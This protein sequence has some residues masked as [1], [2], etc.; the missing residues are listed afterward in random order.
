MPPYLRTRLAPA[1][2]AH[3]ASPTS[4]ASRARGSTTRRSSPP[5]GSGGPTASSI[6]CARRRASARSS[7]PARPRWSSP[8]EPALRHHHLK[9]GWHP[10]ARRPGHRARAAAGQRRRHHEPLPADEPQAELYRNAAADEVLFVHRG[11]GTSAHA[12]SA[13]CPSARFDYVV[14]PRCT[15]YRLEFEPGTQPDLLVFESAGILTIPPRYLNPDGQ[16]RLGAP[17]GERD[18]HGP[19]EAARPRPRGGDHR[20]DQG[21]HAG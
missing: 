18:L 4:P 11:Q 9:T 14:I 13:R 20:P 5:P 10:A 21:R 19:R 3:R 12:C 6:T 7:R 15:T 16:L 17:Y 8:T 1:E 2:A